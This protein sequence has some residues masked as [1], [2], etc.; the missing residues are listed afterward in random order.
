MNFSATEL[1]AILATARETQRIRDAEWQA[2]VELSRKGIEDRFCH[3]QPFRIAFIEDYM[4]WL[5]GFLNN[6][7][8]PTH[9]YNYP[10]SRWKW[11]V[12]LR[13]TKLPPLYGVEAIEIIIPETVRIMGEPGHSNLFF[14]KDFRA[15]GIIPIFSD[16]VF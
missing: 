8:T 5:R 14:M 9:A 6:G 1:N 13:E 12:L 2:H 15:S 16:T 10:W 4:A 7:G 3:P 11:F